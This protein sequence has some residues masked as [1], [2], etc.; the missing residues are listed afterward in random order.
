MLDGR[1]R[2]IWPALK[3]KSHSMNIILALAEYHLTHHKTV[4]IAPWFPP[5]YRCNRTLIGCRICCMNYNSI[6][7]NLK[8]FLEAIPATVHCSSLTYQQL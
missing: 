8:W 3:D 6:V 1:T 7:D 4:F 5:F 2:L